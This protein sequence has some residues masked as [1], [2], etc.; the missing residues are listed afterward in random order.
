[1]GSTFKILFDGF[2]NMLC[3]CV[4]GGA[5]KNCHASESRLKSDCVEINSVMLCGPDGVID[6]EQAQSIKCYGVFFGCRYQ[7]YTQ[8]TQMDRPLWIDVHLHTPSGDL[9]WLITWWALWPG[10]H[11]E[12]VRGQRGY[13]V[14]DSRDPRLR[15]PA[16]AAQAGAF[17]GQ[18]QTT[19]AAFVQRV[20]TLAFYCLHVCFGSSK[21]F[22]LLNYQCKSS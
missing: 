3:V 8:I 17:S 14:P 16:C 4:G 20:C 7:D 18:H 9:T 21:S 11:R 6:S 19:S 2:C 15:G 12:P 22:W 5:H 1:V 13:T 10:N